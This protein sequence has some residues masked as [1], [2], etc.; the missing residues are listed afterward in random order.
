[1]SGWECA[2]WVIGWMVLSTLACM[3]VDAIRRR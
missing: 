1:M 2:A 3:A